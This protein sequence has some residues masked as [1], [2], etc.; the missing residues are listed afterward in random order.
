MCVALRRVRGTARSLR[1]SSSASSPTIIIVSE[2]A[3]YFTDLE[4]QMRR[5]A[6]YLAPHGHLIVSMWVS[7]SKFRR[8]QHVDRALK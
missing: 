5:Y 4:A 6:E 2:V 1:A 3:E 8:W 7:R